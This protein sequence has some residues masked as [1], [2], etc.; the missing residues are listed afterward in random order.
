MHVYDSSRADT[1]YVALIRMYFLCCCRVIALAFEV[2]VGAFAALMLVSG[3]THP[4]G[5]SAMSV[6]LDGATAEISIPVVT[7]ATENVTLESW[8]KLPDN[9]KGCFVKIGDPNTGYGIGVGSAHATFDASNPGNALI[10][11]YENSAWLYP[12]EDPTL[13]TGAWHHVAF[14]IGPAG[15]PPTFYVDGTQ[16]VAIKAGTPIAPTEGAAI[17]KDLGGD[18]S[19]NV[20]L[21]KVAIYNIALSPA[22]ITAHATATSDAT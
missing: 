15:S 12:A 5:V 17:G 20:T 7:T 16:H 18:R 14:V 6:S 21:A 2:V 19:T 8:V 4:A 9:A 10:G 1:G 22:R 11:L 13:S 3:C